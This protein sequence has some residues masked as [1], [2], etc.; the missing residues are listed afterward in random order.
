ELDMIRKIGNNAA[1]GRKVTQ[2]EALNSLRFLFRLTSFVAL[3]YSEQEPGIPVFN[4]ALLPSG[5]EKEKSKHEL[6]K[7]ADRLQEESDR[8][9]AAVAQKQLLYEENQ[10]LKKK[11]EEQGRLIAERRQHREQHV[12]Q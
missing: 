9:Q 2:Y 11:L 8:Y 5:E 7:L 1:H 12:P 4:E 10:Q 6:K 3:Y